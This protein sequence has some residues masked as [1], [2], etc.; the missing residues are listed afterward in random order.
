V[1]F[2][3]IDG[4]KLYGW[5]I[6]AKKENKG[7]TPTLLWFHGNGGN[8]SNRVTNI[9]LLNHYI[10]TNIFIF[11]YRGYGQSE[12]IPSEQGIYRDGEAAVKYLSA[13]NDINPKRMVYFGRSLGASVALE[14]AIKKPPAGIILESPFTSIV[15][16]ARKLYG[17][18]LGKL[19]L[20]RY[21]NES[22]IRQINLPLLILHGDQ[23]Q[24]V[25]F[26]M[27]RTLFDIANEP[28]DFYNIRGAG[29][30]NTD[31]TGGEPYF[32]RLE[33]FVKDLFPQD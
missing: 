20:T 24:I 1:E 17:F 28:K 22:K 26:E 16:M 25:P 8:L 15:A 19:L 2:T 31:I 33:S 9:A 30:N 32:H 23:D 18:P 5:F 13:R 4:V 14:V 3:A 29:H 11:D 6:P 7:I 27:G 10:R 12:G 21:D